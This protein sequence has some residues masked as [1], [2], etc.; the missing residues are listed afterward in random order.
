MALSDLFPR[1]TILFK[2]FIKYY[3]SLIV[4]CIILFLL[5]K[6]VIH[7]IYKYYNK[8]CC[9]ECDYRLCKNILVLNNKT[10]YKEKTKYYYTK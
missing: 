3:L 10:I 7:P 6:Y 8:V 1:Y 9:S 4:I 2:I 5:Y